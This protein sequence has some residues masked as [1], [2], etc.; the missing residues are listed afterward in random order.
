MPENNKVI[1]EKKT[2]KIVYSIWIV[3]VILYFLTILGSKLSSWIGATFAIFT[4]LYPVFLTALL[5]AFIHMTIKR[6][7]RFILI[8]VTLLFVSSTMIW[9]YCPLNFKSEV[10]SNGKDTISIL[11]YNVDIFKMDSRFSA[12]PSGIIRYILN[13]NTDI[14]CL[15]E[16]TLQPMSSYGLTLEEIK[17]MVKDKYPYIRKD[18]AQGSYGS[19]IMVLS[20]YPIIDSEN[21]KLHSPYNGAMSYTLDINGKKVLLINV[22]LESF[23]L[24]L[25]FEPREASI[26]NLKG[27]IKQTTGALSSKR[28]IHSYYLRDEQSNEIVD[29]IKHKAQNEKVILCGDFNATP[30]SYPVSHISSALTNCYTKSGTGLGISFRSSI[31]IVRIDNIFCSKDFTPLYTKVYNDIEL[32]DH[33]PIYSVIKIN[34]K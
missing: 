16:A 2:S 13:K 21:L 18:F 8:V 12:E 26:K 24:R 15:Q 3:T 5:L 7:K 29:Y 1:K 33:Y 22:H 34:D 14:V 4:T 9:S 17:G 20:K 28:I 27:S 10:N 31:F 23:K 11:S 32:S 25:A 6:N 19:S 30:V